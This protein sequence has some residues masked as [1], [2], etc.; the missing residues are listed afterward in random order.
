MG[1]KSKLLS[2]PKIEEIREALLNNVPLRQIA[3]QY[4]TNKSALARYKKDHLGKQVIKAIATEEADTQIIVKK[5]IKEYEEWKVELK[6]LYGKQK[7][8]INKKGVTPALLCVDRIFKALY[9]QSRLVEPTIPQKVEVAINREKLR[10]DLDDLE[11][12][13]PGSTIRLFE[14]IHRTDEEMLNVN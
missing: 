8:K 2:H 14:L 5:L 3:G 1:N 9:G 6:S 10:K 4:G 13:Y 7:A 11:K 12:E